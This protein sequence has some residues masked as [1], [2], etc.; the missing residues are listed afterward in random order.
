VGAVVVVVAA[1]LIYVWAFRQPAI[2]RGND[3]I[4]QADL[5]LVLGNDSL[6]LAQ[7]Q[8]VANS[9]S[10]DAGNRAALQ[11]AILLYKQGKYQEALNYIGK[12]DA[13]ESIISAGAL[14][15]KGDCLVNTD[16][17]DEALACYE[18]AVK[19][20][21]ENPV[22]TPFFMLKQARVYR[23]KADYASEAKI[24]QQVKDE[25]PQYAGNYNIDIDKYIE[26]AKAQSESK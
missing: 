26:R 21:D 13:D 6:A 5:Q 9:D 2:D 23:A 22:Y 7:Y 1:V 24:Y 17:L 12:F 8:A 10:Y 4:G 18:K 14:S 20:S 15:L 19:A 3:A 25:Y 11:A 16:K